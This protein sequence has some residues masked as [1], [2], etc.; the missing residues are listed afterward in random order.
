MPSV[1]FGVIGIKG[2]G[3]GHIDSIRKVEGAELA[4]LCDVAPDARQKAEELGVAY[5]D[6]YRAL[7]ESDA[8]DAVSVCTPHWL[9]HPM[10]MAALRGGKHVF[11]EKPIAMTVREADEMIDAA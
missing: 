8:V 6:D 11:V 4:A 10:A 2:M 3:G 7:A 5:F 9:H 1:R